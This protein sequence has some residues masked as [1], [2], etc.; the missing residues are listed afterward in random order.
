MLSQFICSIFASALGLPV[1]IDELARN[2]SIIPALSDE[3][4]LLADVGLFSSHTN[5][6]AWSAS[7]PLAGRLAGLF[8]ITASPL[9]AFQSGCGLHVSVSVNLAFAGTLDS[10]VW[11]LT[12][13]AEST[14]WELILLDVIIDDIDATTPPLPALTI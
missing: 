9:V 5:R 4:A 13:V 6:V 11:P 7:P 14:D 8:L 3:L 2:I 12:V 10:T 1:V